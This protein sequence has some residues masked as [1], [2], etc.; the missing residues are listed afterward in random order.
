MCELQEPFLHQFKAY[1][2]YTLPKVDVQVALTY[3][4]VP[5][6]VST[7][8]PSGLRANFNASNT[9]LAANSTLGRTLASGAAA[10][11]NVPLQIVSPD[12][13]YLDRDRQLDLR[14]GKVVRWMRTRNTINVDIFNAL[15]SN[16]VLTANN[17]VSSWQTPTSIVNPRLF[18]VSFTIDLK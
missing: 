8:N 14:F 15:N 10:T 2:S 6:F 5:G 4:D 1:G 17:S 9:Y 18:K 7:D 13:V 11:N 16:T 12:V 3:R